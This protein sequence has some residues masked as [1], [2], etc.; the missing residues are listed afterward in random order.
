[1]RSF[2][3]TYTTNG[4][5][6]GQELFVHEYDYALVPIDND[7]DYTYLQNLQYRFATKL[8]YFIGDEGIE[9]KELYCVEGNVCISA[10]KPCQKGEGKI[11]RLYNLTNIEQNV[12]IK[13]EAN[14]KLFVC[15]FYEN[16]KSTIDNRFTI[17]PREIVTIKII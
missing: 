6:G 3:K 14:N 11:L 10:F 7:T 9:N 4:E 13:T 2:R 12:D 16:E 1:M 17:K 8:P 5:N 15:D